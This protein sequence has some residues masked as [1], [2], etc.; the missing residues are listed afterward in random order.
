MLQVT[1]RSLLALVRGLEDVPPRIN[2]F[3][4][5][6]ALVT[7]PALGTPLALR[8]ALL[9]STAISV[10]VLAI[11]PGSLVLALLAREPWEAKLAI[12]KLLRLRSTAESVR[13]LAVPP[14]CLVLAALARSTCQTVCAI[15]PVRCLGSTTP[16]NRFL[17]IPEG[18]LVLALLAREP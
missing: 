18:R 12:F 13:V 14:G 6:A 7:R 5:V 15:F 4:T 9:G 8:P 16:S 11:P 3:V 10:R 2:T 1:A 17:A